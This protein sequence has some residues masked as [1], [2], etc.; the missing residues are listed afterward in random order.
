MGFLDHL[1]EL[2]TRLIRA[3]VA[4]AGGMAITFYF[5]DRVISFI[6]APAQR[7]LPDGTT[8]VFTRPG[9]GLAFHLDVA[10]LGGAILAAPFVMYQVWRFIAPGL[11]AKERRYVVPFVALSV[12][13]TVC[14]AIFTTGSSRPGSRSSRLRR[15]VESG[16]PLPR[17]P[18]AQLGARMNG[19]HEV[20]GS[21]PVWSTNLR[22][23]VRRRLPT[24][25]PKARRWAR[26]RLSQSYG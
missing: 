13:G 7:A 9:E 2:R 6:L 5:V 22:S 17:G 18:V 10:M 19:I 15:V 23:R 8:F 21:I 20:T 11:H 16:F 3:L 24:I 25:A 12:V 4:I 14:G 1:D 26:L